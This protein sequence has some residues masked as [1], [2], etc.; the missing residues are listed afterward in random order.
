MNDNRSKDGFEIQSQRPSTP[1]AERDLLIHS[2][3][4]VFV[5]GPLLVLSRELSALLVP[6]RPRAEFREALLRGLMAAARQKHA[7]AL[8]L[9]EPRTEPVSGG[10]PEKVTQWLRLEPEFGN[11]RW[12]LGAAAVGSA[13]SLAGI[14]A[15]ALRHRNGH[16]LSG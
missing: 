1:V 7:H 5:L 4:P 6:A 14:L 13:V 10:L 15:Y 16:S 9:S 11:R 8:L 2:P 12:V 3:R